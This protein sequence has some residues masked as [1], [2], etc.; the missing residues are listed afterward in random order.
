MIGSLD[1]NAYIVAVGRLEINPRTAAWIW[2]LNRVV[3][4]SAIG[5]YTRAESLGKSQDDLAGE[6]VTQM[7]KPSRKAGRGNRGRA[8]RA[9]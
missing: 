3:G 4:I 6:F 5:K 7:R 8:R 2:T 1:R 9:A